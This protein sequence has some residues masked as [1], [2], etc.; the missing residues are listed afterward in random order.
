VTDAAVATPSRPV[1]WWPVLAYVSATIVALGLAIFVVRIP[2]QLSDGL[3]NLIQVQE[4][5]WYD[6]AK[7]GVASGYMRPALWLQ[8]KAAFLAAAGHYTEVFRAIHAAQIV[9]CALLFVT[10]LRVRSVAALCTVPFGIAVLFALQTFDGTIREAYP[11]NTYLTIVLACL[12][13]FTLAHGRPSRLRDAAAVSLFV[14]MLFT[15]ETGVLVGVVLAAS[16]ATGARGVSRRSVLICAAVLA[17]YV[18]SR[19]V[20]LGG[21]TPGLTERTSG[22]LFGQ[23][24][25]QEIQ[26]RFG[27]FPYGFYLYN[28]LSQMLTVLVG[29]PSGGI[30]VFTRALLAGELRPAH[31]IYEVMVIG[32][33]VSIAAFVRSR[34]A[35]WRRRDFTHEDRIVLVFGAVLVVNA[36]VSFPYT[37]DVIMSPAGAFFAL[38]AAVGVQRWL[39]APAS[40]GWLRTAAVSLALVLLSTAASIRLLA[41]HYQMRSA[42]FVTRNDWTGLEAWA[43]RNQV[44]LSVP[45]RAELAGQLQRDALNQRAPAPRFTEREAGPF[46]HFLF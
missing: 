28:V 1:L 27:G 23:L 3:A 16:W 41:V 15:V 34:W 40:R 8:I 36:L 22:F 18:L 7:D 9:S 46:L 31:V 4:G 45:A 2:V 20:F 37:K 10:A 25:P 33:T 26:A 13:A 38:A 17:A 24:E 32:S 43:D 14:V 11:I 6:V 12:A 21:A 30:F 42:S 19:V 44:D 29:E 39:P 35:S 5:S